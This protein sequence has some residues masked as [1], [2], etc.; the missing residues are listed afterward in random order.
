MTSSV[1]AIGLNRENLLA[2][3]LRFMCK[4][5]FLLYSCPVGHLTLQPPSLH[6]A[7]TM[8]LAANRHFRE[9]L[10]LG[11]SIREKTFDDQSRPYTC[12]FALFHPSGCMEKIFERTHYDV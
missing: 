7:Y 6:Y 11:P 10:K 9:A 8:L 2:Y 4:G 5:D 12:T 3:L 1:P